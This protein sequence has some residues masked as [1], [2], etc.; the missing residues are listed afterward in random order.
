MLLRNNAS[1]CKDLRAN[2]SKEGEFD[3]EQLLSLSLLSLVRVMSQ[4]GPILTIGQGLGPPRSIS[5]WG[6]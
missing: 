5:T 6:P 3:A 2:P 4:V 1:G